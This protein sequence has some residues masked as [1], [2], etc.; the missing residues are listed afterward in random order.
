MNSTQMYRLSDDQYFNPVITYIYINRIFI[1]W[2]ICD[3]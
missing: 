2:L 1:D 3:G